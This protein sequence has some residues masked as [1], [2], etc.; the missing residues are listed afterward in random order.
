MRHGRLAEGA[1]LRPPDRR[2][3]SCCWPR[4]PPRSASA[5]TP[6][7]RPAS[8]STARATTF[9]LTKQAPVISYGQYADAIVATARRTDDSAPSDQVMVICEA[10]GVTLTPISGWDTF[11]LPRHLLARLHPRGHAATATWCSTTRS[12]TSP[13]RPCCRPRTCSGPRCGSAWP[14]RP[15]GGPSASSRGPPART[16]TSRRPGATRLAALMVTRQQFASSIEALMSRY[17]E[18]MDEPEATSSIDFMVAIN[19]LKVSASTLVVDIINQ[20]MLICRDPGLPRGL[21]V[22]PRPDPARRPRRG[23]DGQQRPDRR[24]HRP[25]RPGAAG[26]L[27]TAVDPPAP[28]ATPEDLRA[29][30]AGRRAA[31]RDPHGRAST[32]ARATS[33][34]CCRAS[35]ATPPTSGSTTRCRAGGSRRSWPR[36]DFLLTDYLRSFPDLVGSIDVFT[37]GDKEHRSCSPSSRRAG[38]GPV[39]RPRPRSCSAPR[40]ATASTARCRPTSRPAGCSTSAAASPSGTSRAS[41]RPGCSRSGCTSSCSSARPTEAVAHRD[42]W[43]QRGLDVARGAR[44]A[45]AHRDRQRP[46]L[47]PGR[48]DAGR[49]PADRGAQ[50][51]GGHRP[52]RRQGDGD[53]LGELP[54]GPLRPAVRHA[55]RPTARS[56]TAPASAT[57]WSGSPWR[58]SPPTGWTS[59]AGPERS[60][61][62]CSVR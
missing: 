51:R 35:S 62:P 44:P 5:A 37:G 50:V 28:Y 4:P 58:C 56:R 7:T 42:L 29:R 14:R 53:R 13:P 54:R 9:R 21:R 27:M 45:G 36:E 48:P 47:R 3:S 57:A 46:V 8:W 55:P 16:S 40:S 39:A 17:L 60:A 33:S 15:P 38:T 18:I 22:L 25:A 59:R 43:L 12:A 61:P 24:Q 41:T 34:G 26:D 11:G 52:H 23:G 1:G 49:Q 2:R 6:A 32:T 19:T 10:A 31:R 30:P 20:A